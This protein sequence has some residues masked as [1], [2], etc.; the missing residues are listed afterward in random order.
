MASNSIPYELLEIIVD[1][2]PGLLEMT[3]LGG[4]PPKDI[5]M[6]VKSY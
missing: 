6:S 3:S 5:E 1:E 2:L 4:R